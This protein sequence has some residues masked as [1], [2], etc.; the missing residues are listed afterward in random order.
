MV[1]IDILVEECLSFSLFFLCNQ[2]GL[3][4]GW[5]DGGSIAFAVFLVIIVTGNLIN[6]FF[7][8]WMNK[9]CL[10]LS[11]NMPMSVNSYI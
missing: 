1:D 2:K 9:T 8:A 3:E 4:E 11:F 6:R 5:Y 7:L 10:A